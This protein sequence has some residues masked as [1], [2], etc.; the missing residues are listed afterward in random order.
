[1]SQLEVIVVSITEGI[2]AEA[3]YKMGLF[4]NQKFTTRT[5]I[6]QLAQ[7]VTTQNKNICARMSL[8][9][10]LMTI[11]TLQTAIDCF[12]RAMFMEGKSPKTQRSYYGILD[13]FV[14]FMG[15]V[16]VDTITS[17]DIQRYSEDV[18][19]RLIIYGTKSSN[20][21]NK[22]YSVVRKLLRWLFEK[23]IMTN[24]ITDL[25]K[26]PCLAEELPE[27]LT[28]EELDKIFRYLES[29]TFRDLVIFEVFLDTGLLLEELVGLTLDD[30]HLDQH[31]LRVIGKG[32][33]EDFIPFG[34]KVAN[35]LR[36]YIS[37]DRNNTALPGE[38]ALFVNNRD[39]KSV[40]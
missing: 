33:K 40:V 1:M 17:E 34:E 21:I 28:N 7:A 25:T 32:G 3:A 6:F 20:S 29:Q 22:Y 11:R 12:M 27:T 14:K 31:M 35:D 24:R 8:M 26:A 19:S 4:W 9:E 38:R 37:S 10:E 23:R 30:V 2:A 18:T 39:R 16:P 36:K 15:D 5:A 13:D